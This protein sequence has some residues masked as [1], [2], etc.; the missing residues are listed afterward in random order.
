[1][2]AVMSLALALLYLAGYTGFSLSGFVVVG[3]VG[4]FVGYRINRGTL[5][6]VR[7]PSSAAAVTTE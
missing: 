1:M 2:G 5:P 4:G 3:V 6:A 7:V